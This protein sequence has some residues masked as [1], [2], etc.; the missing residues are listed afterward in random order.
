VEPVGAFYDTDLGEFVLPYEEVRSAP[1]PDATLMRFLQTTYAAAAELADWP[2]H[3]LEMAPDRRPP[4]TR[5]VE[6]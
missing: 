6:G 5:P 4:W 1:D 3:R 2:R